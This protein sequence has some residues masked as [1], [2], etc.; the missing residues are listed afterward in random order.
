MSALKF[1]YL[2]QIN[3]GVGDGV[4]ALVVPADNDN[5]AKVYAEAT[6]RDSRFASQA[7]SAALFHHEVAIARWSCAAVTRLTA[8]PVQS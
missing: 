3:A 4:W 5:D 2:L 6:L 7:R 8:Q 1:E